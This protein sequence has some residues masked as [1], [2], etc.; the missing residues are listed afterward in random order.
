MGC[1]RVN[2][3]GDGWIPPSH[4][5]Q[6]CGKY[7]TAH[8]GG[9][10]VVVTHGGGIGCGG[11]MAHEGLHNAALFHQ[12]GVYLHKSDIQDIHRVGTDLGG[13]SNYM[14]VGSES[15]PGGMG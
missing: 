3:E 15:Y 11:D 12:Q 14:L 7:G 13:E 4:C 9:G 8:W 1:R 5:S 2:D 10:M 6:D